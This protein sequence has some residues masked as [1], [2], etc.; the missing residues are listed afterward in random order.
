MDKQVKDLRDKK[1]VDFKEDDITRVA[2]R[3]PDGD[4]ILTKAEGTWKIEQP[5][6]FPADANAVRAL[7]SMVRNLRAT[8]FAS[9]A[10]SD[11]D[12]AAY[13]LD[14]PLRQLAFISGDGSETRLLVGKESEQGLYVKTADRPTTFIVGKWASRDLGKGVNDLRDKTILSFAAD[15]ATVIDIARADGGHFI[16]RSADGKWSIEGSDQ[17]IDAAVVGTF[18]GALSHLSGNQVLGDAP[19]SDLAAFGLAS[20]AVTV[21]VK[22][23]DDVLIGAILAG[24]YSPQPPATEYTV[25]R[26]DQ[27]TVFQL[28]DFQFK[29]LDRK[30]ADFVAAPPAPPGAPQGMPLEAGDEEEAE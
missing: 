23:K 18:V 4:V 8:D 17:E 10:P 20:P 5:A 24:S 3:G 26:T 25:K 7:L 15:A 27:P 19:P 11:A 2:L 30:P 1:I 13:G 6:A 22:G 28:R 16:L 21:T 14:S 12:L 9:D 29:Q